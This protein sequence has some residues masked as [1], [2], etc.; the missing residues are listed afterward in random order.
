MAHAGKCGAM[1]IADGL[2]LRILEEADAAELHALIE[3]NRAFLARRLPWAAGQSRADT[4]DFVGRSR[5]QLLGDESFQTALVE[6]GSI[7]GMAGF[8]SLVWSHR[9]GNIGYW[10]AEEH[11]GRG[12]VTTA[13]RRLVRH[14]FTVWELERIEIRAAT[15]NQRSRA[16]PERLGFKREGVLHGAERLGDRRLD[17]VVYATYR[18]ARE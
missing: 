2:S 9:S 18:D 14:A 13:V 10:L 16:V 4:E 5:D 8:S 12:H 11:Q 1:L 6:D 7:I 15:D 3:A 17:L